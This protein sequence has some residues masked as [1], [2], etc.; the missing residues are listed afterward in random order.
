METTVA[1]LTQSRYDSPAFNAAIYDGAIRVYFAQHQEPEA[2]KIYFK[3]QER[4]RERENLLEGGSAYIFVMLYPDAA[5]FAMSFGDSGNKVNM[6]EFET[7][8]V[9][10][11]NGPIP[12]DDPA[13]YDEICRR[14]LTALDKVYLRTSTLEAISESRL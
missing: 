6:E 12:N 11:V 7:N 2:L 4:V 13:V 5:S 14:V 8:F 3:I 1:N 10:G 9:V